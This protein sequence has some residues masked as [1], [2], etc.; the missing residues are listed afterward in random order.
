MG[1]PPIGKRPMTARERQQRH[2]AGLSHTVTK[3]A[4]VTKQ[5]PVAHPITRTTPVIPPGADA[6]PQRLT[7]DQIE[8]WADALDIDR[9]ELERLTRVIGRRDTQVT[10]DGFIDDPEESARWL[11]RE[12]GWSALYEI[13]EAIDKVLD[14]DEDEPVT[15]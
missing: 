12:L 3:P 15:K 13:S 8:E 9:N 11:L 7:E 5:P 2:R 10:L 4:P 14:E 1:R 6:L